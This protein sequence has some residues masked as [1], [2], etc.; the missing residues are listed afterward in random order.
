MI[1]IPFFYRTDFETQKIEIPP[2]SSIL[3]NIKTTHPEGT[4][5]ILDEIIYDNDL[6]KFPACIVKVKNETAQKLHNSSIEIPFFYRTDFETQ[7][8]EIPP[9]SSILKN[10]K[11]THPEGTEIILDEIIY[12]NDL[13]KFPACIVKV[14]NETVCLEI[15]NPTDQTQLITLKPNFISKFGTVFNSEDHDC[16][17]I[18]KFGTVFNSEDHDCCHIEN[19]VTPD[20]ER[21]DY[22]S[23]FQNLRTNHLNVEEK[24]LLEKVIKDFADIF[25]N[26]SHLLTFTNKIKH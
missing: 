9:G 19:I 7:K 18:D 2:G 13:L 3:K 1:E 12:D 25:H 15:Q 26:E 16:C 11:T 14:K 17:H 20:Y 10:I 22:K 4:E 23:L 6:L 8:I 24:R 21:V 5:I